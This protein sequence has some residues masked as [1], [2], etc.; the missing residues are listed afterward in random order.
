MPRDLVACDAGG[1][2]T[3]VI[4]VDEQ[5]FVDETPDAIRGGSGGEGN[6][7]AR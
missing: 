7:R 2:L 6:R 5:E 3:D 1:K 4:A